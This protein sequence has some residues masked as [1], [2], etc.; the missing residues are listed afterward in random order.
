MV[1]PTKVARKGFSSA[2][3]TF[4]RR[5]IDSVEQVEVLLILRAN[6]ARDWSIDEISAILRSSAHSIGARL[7]GLTM[8][9][10]A[11]GTPEHGYRYAASGDADAAIEELEREYGARR[12]SVIEM[13]FTKPDAARN[14]ADAF[15]LR[16]TDEDDER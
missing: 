10:F 13:I 6:P 15:R 11:T 14:F 4:V 5:Y 12:F 9:G 1:K 7:A 2:F 3:R 16:S 8:L